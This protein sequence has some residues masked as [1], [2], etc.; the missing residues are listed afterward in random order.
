MR[1]SGISSRRLKDPTALLYKQIRDAV[2][3]AEVSNAAK[4]ATLSLV[5]H[6]LLANMRAEIDADG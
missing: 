1:L 4:V 5:T 6:E 2:I 3:N